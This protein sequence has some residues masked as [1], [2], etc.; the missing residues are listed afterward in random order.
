[1]GG[2]G[3]FALLEQ[4]LDALDRSSVA[5]AIGGS[6]AGSFAG[7]PRSTVDVDVAVEIGPADLDRVLT[8]LPPD[9]LGL[10]D[11]LHRALAEATP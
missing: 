11:D 3:P 1:M 9:L 2:G 6:V 7:E 10:G 5:Y 4:I 8:A